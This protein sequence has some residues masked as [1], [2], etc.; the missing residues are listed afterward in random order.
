PGFVA[1]SGCAREPLRVTQRVV[2]LA[3]HPQSVQEYGE[4]ACD[5]HDG[6]LPRVAAAALEDRQAEAA[7]V[8]VLTALAQDP[9]RALD[10]AGA[11]QTASGFRDPELG[12]RVSRVAL[13]RRETAVGTDRSTP[14]EAL[15][16]LDRQRI[17]ER[18]HR[19]D[20][21]DLAQML[22]HGVALACDLRELA[23]DG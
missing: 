12:A 23:I 7:Q 13:L 4:L 19:T 20:A 21:I 8:T 6:A 3:R 18:R 10:Q 15:G 5:R 17:G 16:I 22:G 14:F 9:L 1:I 11:Q 2:D